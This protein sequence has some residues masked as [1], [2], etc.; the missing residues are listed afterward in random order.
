MLVR[1]ALVLAAVVLHG[2]RGDISPAAAAEVSESALQAGEEPEFG[3]LPAGLGREAVYYT[4]RACHSLKQFTQQNMDRGDW[5]AVIDRMVAKNGMEAPE[6][7]AFT[8]ILAY[9]ST[10][11]GVDVQDF[12]GLPPGPGREEVF[13]TCSAC[14]SIRMV[15]Q[16]RLRRDVWDE[17]LTWMVEEQEMPELEADERQVILDYLATFLSDTT[18]R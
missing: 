13:Y 18:P 10:H 11:F 5:H 15:T 14:H 6:P 9:L 17:T 12:M 2:G 8:L 7:W 16:Q 1:A 4:C 3:G